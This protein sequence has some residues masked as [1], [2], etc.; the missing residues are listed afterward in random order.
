[1]YSFIHKILVYG[2]L[3]GNMAGR[4]PQCWPSSPGFVGSCLRVLREERTHGANGTST[5]SGSLSTG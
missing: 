4:W 5:N 2:F 1:M 3:I